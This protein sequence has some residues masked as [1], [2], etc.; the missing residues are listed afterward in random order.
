MKITTTVTEKKEVEKE[1]TLPFY[2]YNDGYHFAIIEP[3]KVVQVWAKYE[4]S[5]SIAYRTAPSSIFDDAANGT[6]CTEQE[7]NE[8]LKRAIGQ[9][10]V[11]LWID[12]S[13]LPEPSDFEPQ[14]SILRDDDLITC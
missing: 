13:P 7:F 14:Y 8:A 6:P 4:D 12:I 11:N 1:I 3:G 5:M 2:S 10:K 9:I